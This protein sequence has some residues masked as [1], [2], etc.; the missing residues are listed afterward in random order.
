MSELVE[1]T[2]KV[3][4]EQVGNVYALVGRLLNPQVADEDQEQRKSTKLLPWGEGDE[5]KAKQVYA[6]SSSYAR[7]ALLY[8]VSHA[9]E[10][11]LGDEIAPEV[12]LTT[13][14]I[15][16]AGVLS[17]VGRQCTKVGRKMPYET[18]PADGSTAV[19]YIMQREVADLFHAAMA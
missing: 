5:A 14:A 16:L 7:R 15:G 4:R 11:K 18:D 9:E 8:F 6:R 1:V 17:S 13:G 2:V 19:R 10:P 3:P 12:G